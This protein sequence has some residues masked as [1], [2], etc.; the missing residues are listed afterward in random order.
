MNKLDSLARSCYF[1]FLTVFFF[2]VSPRAHRLSSHP[3]LKAF[4]FQTKLALLP[5]L[6]LVPFL[7]WFQ[8]FSKLP[9]RCL[10]DD[11]SDATLHYLTLSRNPSP[12]RLRGHGCFFS[13][14]KNEQ[15]ELNLLVCWQLTRILKL[16]N[17]DIN[18]SCGCTA[19]EGGKDKGVP[20]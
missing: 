6:F 3:R 20:A 12:E 15:A 5:W 9:L 8:A 17:L 4:V 18:T 7:V 14:M 10:P 2:E 16:T 1:R 19:R 13:N 11:N